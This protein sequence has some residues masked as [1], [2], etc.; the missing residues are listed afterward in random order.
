M[1]KYKIKNEIL[2]HWKDKNPNG[3]FLDAAKVLNSVKV[4]REL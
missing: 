3:L 1:D 2:S 4:F